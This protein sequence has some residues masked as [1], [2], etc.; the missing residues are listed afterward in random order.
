MLITK[1]SY[2]LDPVVLGAVS[3]VFYFAQCLIRLK[4]GLVICVTQF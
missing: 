3:L 2:T 4:I 1:L